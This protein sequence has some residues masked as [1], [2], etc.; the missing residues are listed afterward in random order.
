M[1]LSLV[2][3]KQ[4]TQTINVE[5]QVEKNTLSN[6]NRSDYCGNI[7]QNWIGKTIIVKGW[8]D[9][10]RDL[11]ALVFV[12]LRDRSGILQIVIDPNKP[13]LEQAKHLG[14]EYVLAVQG[15]V[16]ERPD[17]NPK[18]KTGAIEIEASQMEIL[19]A[20]QVPPFQVWDENTSETTRLKYR[21]LDLRSPRLQNNLAVRH[22][23]MQAFREFLNNENFLEIE[24]PILYKS[25]P[26][27]ARDYLVPSRV[28]SG[29]FY[30][31]PQSPQTLKQL[32]MIGSID[33]YYQ[34]AR[35]FR[36]EDLRADRQP[37]FS[38]IDIEMSFVESRDV[39]ELTEALIKY[40]WKKVKGES[41]GQ[42]PQLTYEY[43]IN[44]YGSDRP[45][46]RFDMKIIDLKKH[47]EHSGFK[48]FDSVLESGGILR[49][50]VA[51]GAGGFSRKQLDQITEFVK[52]HKAKG[53]V[54]IKW[55]ANDKI[56]SSV[57]KFFD[58]KKLKDVL[59]DAGAKV[60][61]A[62]FI[63]ADQHKITCSSLGALRLYLGRELELI[64]ESKYSFLWVTDFPLLEFDE[65]QKRWMACHHPF[66]QPQD[67][68]HQVVLDKK[69]DQL[70][71][72]KAK[73][74]DFV[75]NGNELAG[76]SIRIHQPDLQQ[77]LFECLGLS[78]DEIQLKFGFFVEALKYGT[79]PHG[80]IAWGLDRLVMLM[81]NT[82]AIRDVIAFP[83][84]TRASCLM[85]E[86]PSPVDEA[87]LKELGLS[88]NSV[89]CRRNEVKSEL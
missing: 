35:C 55:E 29:Q 13:G 44:C 77:A 63:V 27:G 11:G 59:T 40:V 32:L 67:D 26:E 8:V 70:I 6:Q 79:P 86:A 66:T 69:T 39:L 68:G 57:S 12:D 84:T 4:S 22:Q 61:D 71:D 83:K 82:E 53:L 10:R 38:Q 89:D 34:V 16:C 9:T 80:G 58:E 43:A 5:E 60:G 14:N 52:I 72:V 33:R 87:Q 7:D 85:S 17:K 54:W 37:E 48:V 56:N 36:D 3:L 1:D 31:L 41:I 46:L 30:A 28:H 20:S 73:A 50:L 15:L 65:E 75:C 45:D 74:Y 62:L 51:P 78:S 19:T 42:I 64:D 21:Y 81:C 76:G 25:T 24:T 23:T 2:V 88:L 47:F 49:G 18:L